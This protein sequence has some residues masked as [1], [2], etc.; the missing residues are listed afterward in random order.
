MKNLEGR[1][2]LRTD[3]NGWIEIST[4]GNEMWVLVQRQLPDNE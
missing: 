1:S 2:V 4:D 3:I